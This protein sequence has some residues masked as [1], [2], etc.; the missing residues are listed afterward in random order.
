MNNACKDT[1]VLG[2][3][4]E[5]HDVPRI[6]SWTSDLSLAKNALVFTVIW[7]GIPIVYA[8]QEQHYSGYA[9]PANREATWL[10]GYDQS[11]ELYKTTTAMNAVRNRV[12]SVDSGYTTYGIKA[13]YHDTHTA[14][15][16]KGND[17]NQIVSVIT[18]NGEGSSS[19]T[20]SLE[21]TGWDA[22]TDVVEILT[23]KKSS[24]GLDGKLSVPMEKGL[25]RVYVAE[26]VTDGSKICQ[27]SSASTEGGS[28]KGGAV[29]RWDAGTMVWVFGVLLVSLAGNIL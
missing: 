18:N 20:L 16:R 28:K 23:C 8:G 1:S 6:A 24:V 27:D 4:T 21:Q 19:S 2:V 25:P 9:D 13:I 29:G 12:I 3:F 26:A 11:S 14:A 5:S 17:G 22:G 7:D 15:F 10:S